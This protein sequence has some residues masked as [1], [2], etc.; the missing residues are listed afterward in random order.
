MSST[1]R[2]SVTIAAGLACVWLLTL[3]SLNRNWP[4]F[5]FMTAL[6][7]SSFKLLFIGILLEAVP[8]MLLG[9]TV[10]AFLHLTVTE[11]M[12]R[13][14]IPKKPIPGIL[15]ACS[16]GLL[17]PL[18]ECGMIPIVRRLMRKGM[19]AYIAVVF[20]LVGPILNPV[21]F[22]STYIA[23]RTEPVLAYAR[24]GLA[25]LVALG[26]GLLLHRFVR[27]N[28]LRY[29]ATQLS[30]ST[31]LSSQLTFSSSQPYLER[32]SSLLAHASDEFFEMGKYLILGAA[33]TAW[34]QTA[35]SPESLFSI[36]QGAWSSHLF[37]MG[38]AYMLSLCSTSDA[39]VVSAFDATFLKGSLLTF[40]VFGPMLDF[41]NTLMLLAVF[42]TKFVLLL[43]LLVIGFVLTGSKLL[44]LYFGL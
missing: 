36:G 17:F 8:F 10:S 31:A 42:R 11:E 22:A 19:P 9:V 38:L 30:A 16:L 35:F 44:E 25:F 26:I 14:W 3:I 4:D 24:M 39:F 27:T 28:P 7:W 23:F 2:W 13:R 18:C 15:F 21:V 40:L 5:S 43:S 20:I 6:D 1:H 37:M 33:M 41:K 32:G 34:I 29:H 12:V